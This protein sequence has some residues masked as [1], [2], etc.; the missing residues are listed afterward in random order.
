MNSSDNIQ[1][2]YYQ[3]TGCTRCPLSA[4]REG[5]EIFFGYGSATATYLIVGSA[6][7]DSDEEMSGLFQGRANK[8]LFK[9]LESAKIDPD[10]CYFTYAVSCRP[11][12]YIPATEQE[13]ER[14]ESRA[15]TKEEL[16]ACRPR[17]YELLYQV[18]PRAVIAFGEPAA[19]SLLRGRMAKFTDV[20]G[21]LYTSTLPAAAP[22][23]RAEGKT[24]GKSRY[25]DVAY[26]VFAVPDL[27]TILANPSTAT[28]GPHRV[29]VA[30]LEHAR[31]YVQFVIHNE[32]KNL[33][34]TR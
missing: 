17:L 25:H 22:E 13:G 15:P 31:N 7:T 9:A 3:W 23:D 2:L 21:K 19:K 12:V 4:T 26:P 18:D 34:E 16:T 5:S 8:V 28:H 10:D 14:I 24:Q 29:L 11:K 1:S 32:N 20:V 30:T 27:A 6:P 33:K